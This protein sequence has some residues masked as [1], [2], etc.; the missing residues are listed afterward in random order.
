MDQTSLNA[1]IA[2]QGAYIAARNSG[3]DPQSVQ[4]NSEA[5]LAYLQTRV[6]LL[7][8]ERDNAVK[9]YNDDIA[10]YEQQIGQIQQLLKTNNSSG[11]S[12]T[13]PTSQKN[14]SAQHSP[15]KA[16]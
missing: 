16:E 8:Q 12:V 2:A 7:A 3:T 5:M 15:A 6:A 13:T 14:A 11:T 1:L 9:S 4:A 10:N